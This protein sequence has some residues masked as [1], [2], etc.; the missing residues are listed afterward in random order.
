MG[1]G[2]RGS[3]SRHPARFYP[4]IPNPAKIPHNFGANP[5]SRKRILSVPKFTMISLFWSI[6]WIYL[7]IYLEILLKQQQQVRLNST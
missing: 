1:G 4:S 2:S 3:E 5:A 6:W 7:E